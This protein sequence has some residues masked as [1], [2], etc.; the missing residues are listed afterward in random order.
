MKIKNLLNKT[1]VKITIG[2]VLITS[3]ILVYIAFLTVKTAQD[4]FNNATIKFIDNRVFLVKQSP[5]A[6]VEV[7]RN[8]FNQN[9][10]GAIAYSGV[11]GILLSVTAG[12]IFSLII[13]Q[14][15][16]RISEGIQ[17][18]KKSRYKKKIELTGGSEFDDVINEFNELAEELAY[19]DDLRKD[20][21]SDIAHELRT[22]LTSIL[23]Q[24][25][26]MRDGVLPIDNDRLDLILHSV[27]RLN[28]LIDKLQE[29]TKIR[30]QVSKLKREQIHLNKLV[31]NIQN[32]REM[33]LQKKEIKFI[34]DIDNSVKINADKHL[35]ERALDNIID[36]SIKYSEA[37]E[38]KVYFDKVNNKLIISDNGKGVPDKE[39][40][41]IF[42]RFYRVEKSRSRET[43]GLGLGLALVKE[44]VES[45]GWE[46]EAEKNIDGGIRFELK[47]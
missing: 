4:E 1:A 47:F 32:L 41:K 28:Q 12:A 38:I 26:G 30:S 37:T 3:F 17:N 10:L 6:P 34:I 35:V 45:H 29:Y 5:V 25:Q 19:Q 14:P 31:K 39:L 7:I 20:L 22:P 42:E 23:G 43:G 18:I 15:L 13:T 44:I 27:N 24:T 8:Q 11:L 2:V 21:I 36:N 40:R 33:D 16:R 46:I 9:L